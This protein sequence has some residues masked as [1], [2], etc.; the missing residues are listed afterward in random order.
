MRQWLTMTTGQGWRLGCSLYEVESVIQDWGLALLRAVG[1][2][3]E[4]VRLLAD[5]GEVLR[6]TPGV[7]R[8]TRRPSAFETLE[9]PG[10]A[11]LYQ[12]A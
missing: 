7:D 9:D 10:G 11:G 4:L 6:N 8:R 5:L 12:G 3:G 1:N 2:F